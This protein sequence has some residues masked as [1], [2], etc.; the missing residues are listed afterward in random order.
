MHIA[1][2]FTIHY[3][4]PQSNINSP[5]KKTLFKIIQDV[6]ESFDALVVPK[7]L[8]LSILVNSSHSLQGHACTNK[9]TPWSWDLFGK[10]CTDIDRFIQNCHICRKHN[11][12]KHSYGFIH[13]NPPKRPFHSIALNVIGSFPLGSKENTYLLTSMCLLTNYSTAIAIPNKTAKKKTS[14]LT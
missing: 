11:L 2:V 14:K 8:A 9:H 5:W 4:Y 6:D 12:H 7:P 3:T 13:T 10:D 1:N